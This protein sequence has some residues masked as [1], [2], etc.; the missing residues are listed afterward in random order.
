M[1]TP[2]PRQVCAT[3]KFHHLEQL[4]GQIL[5]QMVCHRFPPTISLTTTPQGVQGMTLFP[6]V[7]A[8]MFCYEWSAREVE[9]KKEDEPEVHSFADHIRRID[10]A[11]NDPDDTPGSFKGP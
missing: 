5:K 7:Q 11:K 2:I 6:V 10:P 8:V 3:C 1:T 4:Q 9:P